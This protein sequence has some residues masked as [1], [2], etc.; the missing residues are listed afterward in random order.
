MTDKQPQGEKQV[1]QRK[2]Y[3]L[4]REHIHRGVLYQPGSKVELRPDQ[5]ERLHRRG[6]I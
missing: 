4:K 3:P 6:V 2:S 5:A 1:M